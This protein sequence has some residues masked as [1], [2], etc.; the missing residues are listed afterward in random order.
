MPFVNYRALKN[1]ESAHQKVKHILSSLKLTPPRPILDN[2]NDRTRFS[3]FEPVTSA[4]NVKYFIKI[5][6]FE[7]KYINNYF[8]KN[9]VLG[10]A[11]RN[12]QLQKL[13]RYTPTLIEGT[14]D[15]LIYKYVQGNNYGN[16][17]Y[18]QPSFIV[19]NDLPNLFQIINAVNEFPISLLPKDYEVHGWPYMMF[20]IYKEGEITER[21][22]E[23][24]KLF[25][26][27]EYSFI[28][29]LFYNKKLE[30]IVKTNSDNL[31]HNDF[32]PTNFINRGTFI[33]IVDWDNSGIDH[34]FYDLVKFYIVH[35]RKRKIQKVIFDFALQKVVK[36]KE[37]KIIYFASLIARSIVECTALIKEKG[38]DIR[39]GKQISLLKQNILKTRIIDTKYWISQLSKI[40]TL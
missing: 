11:L 38:S 25:S 29:S 22:I 26:S 27:R 14:G 7:D 13:N 8:Y 20:H 16:R 12:N 15:Y 37:D 32:Q 1:I 17:Y 21:E 34:K 30:Q 33:Q 39:Q 18:Y 9:K 3:Y 31:S 36:T 40:I 5:K 2:L 10:D 6:L 4:K 23:Y 24:K 19:M 28:S 35:Y